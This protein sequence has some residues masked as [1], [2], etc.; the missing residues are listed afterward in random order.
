LLELFSQS[1]PINVPVKDYKD[2][3]IGDKV[4][5]KNGIFSPGTVTRCRTVTM[6]I[7]L[8]NQNISNKYKIMN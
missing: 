3:S 5:I 7:K 8:N 6:S 4:I 2:Q 1:S